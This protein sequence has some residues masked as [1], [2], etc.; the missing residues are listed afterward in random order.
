MVNL[1]QL[2]FDIVSVAV[3]AAVPGVA[4]ALVFLLAWLR[5]RF[6]QSVGLG[7]PEFWLLLP[8]ALA[9]SFALLPIAPISRDVVALSFTGAVFPLL[10]G[11]LA[12]GK[13]APPTGRSFGR[14]ALAL[15]IV[16]GAAL[17]P[18]VALDPGRAAALGERLG[19]APFAAVDL[20]VMVTALGATVVLAAYLSRDRSA[21]GCR[22]FFAFVA[23]V[24]VLL[25]T[26]LAASSVPG[27]GI[28]ET[29]PYF[30]IPPVV[31]G[32]VL[33]LLAGRFAPGEEGYALPLAFFA[34]GWGPTLGADVLRQP[35]LYG[36][37]TA[38]LYVIGGAGVLDL[39]Y[40]SGFVALGVATF[41]HLG[42]GRSLRPLGP[43]AEPPVPSPLGRL[44]EAYDRG[45]R[46]DLNGSLAASAEAARSAADQARR[47]TVGA[48]SAASAR[49]WD[50]LPVPGWVVSDQAN[51]EAIARSGT[52]EPEEAL[53]GWL[54]AR[55]LVRAGGQ[56]ARGRFASVPSR[57]LAFLVDLAVVGV[58]SAAVL[59]V[60]AAA[61]PGTLDDLLASVGYNAAIYGCITAAFLYLVVSERYGGTTLG[62]RWVGIEVLDRRGRRPGGIAALVRNAS[63][64]PTV[65]LVFV[66]LSLLIA[67]LAKGIGPASVTG[68]SVPGGVLAVI[69]VTTFVAAGAALFG[70][71]G[72]LAIGLTFERQRIGDLWAGT[73][74]VRVA[75]GAR[76]GAR[77]GPAEPGP[78]FG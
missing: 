32:L 71:L 67:L 53:R 73:W 11:A 47:L 33:V 44:E 70:A 78:P 20:A 57:V 46:G 66:G 49:P 75:T 48:A 40:L 14:I 8:A 74:V 22:L 25:L 68:V 28:V 55:W 77:T 30:L 3:S 1:P 36:S 56:I 58:L 29:F 69:G 24:L 72:I 26:F 7:R 61:S 31:A 54:T 50:G 59:G 9:A 42:L 2:S 38:G 45:V 23:T 6:A 35:G 34:G 13:A 17:V 39:V 27:V 43:P 65:T 51:L 19:L 63:L 5:P 16:T 18:D 15:G 21:G 4:W 10:V 64:L 41:L 62:K 60:F 12:L 52:G 37:G 76:P